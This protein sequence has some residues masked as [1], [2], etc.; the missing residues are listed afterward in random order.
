[1]VRFQSVSFFCALLFMTYFRRANCNERGHLLTRFA[2]ELGG[3]NV[4]RN[5]KNKRTKPEK[6]KRKRRAK[7]RTNN[8][9]L[10]RWLEQRKNESVYNSKKESDRKIAKKLLKT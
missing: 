6:K 1:M 4:E 8:Y 10:S 9:P 2:L 7:L 3:N 5:R